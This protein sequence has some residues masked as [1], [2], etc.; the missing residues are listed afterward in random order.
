[1]SSSPAT[2]Y[3]NADSSTPPPSGFFPVVYISG[4]PYQMGYQYGLQAGKYM[5]LS[6][7]AVWGTVLSEYNNNVT[8]VMQELKIYN[9]YVKDNLTAINY[10][11]I[12]QGMAD[13]AQAAGYNVSY[14]DI[15]LINYRVEFEFGLIPGLSDPANSA[16]NQSSACT[17]LAVWGNATSNGELITGSNFDYMPG[18]SGSYQVLVIA[19]PENGN[20]F[21]SIG[22]A[23]TLFTNFGMNNKGVVIESNKA[24]NGRPQDV[25]YGISDFIMDPYALM[26]AS[27]ATEAKNIIVSLPKTNGINRLV[28]D[29]S[30]TAYAIESTASLLGIRTPVNGDYIITTNHFLNT[31]MMPAQVPWNPLAYYPA[32]Y[33]RYITAQKYIMMNYGNITP[34]TVMGIMSSTSYWNGSEWIP[35]SEW[36]GNTINRFAPWGGTLSSKVAI[37][38]QG[39]LYV[40]AGNPGYP[41]WGLLAPGQTG[42][43]VKFVL[44]PSDPTPQT[45]TENLQSEAYGELFQASKALYGIKQSDVPTYAQL[46]QQ[47]ANAESLYWESSHEMSLATLDYAQGNLNSALALYGNASTGFAEVQGIAEY[48]VSVSKNYVSPSSQLSAVNSSLSAAIGSTNSQLGSIS[49]SL[50]SVSNLLSSMSSTLS[51]MSSTVSSIGDSLSSM[52]STLSTVQ[53]EAAQISSI[54]S[55]VLATIVIAIIIL[56]LEILVL[57]RRR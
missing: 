34:Q 5:E 16:N 20:A 40:C 21:V 25:G 55:L 10:S 23:G 43:Y 49:S 19:Y 2:N 57:I 17:N 47:F 41:L 50:S 30:G 18:S 35:N 32:S 27:N 29:T 15:L 22:F 36:T 8:F 44:W 54:N 31:T 38:A 46:S 45:I 12:M 33:Y 14:W 56:V 9:S 6:K 51:T 39:I 1:M 11:A 7:D 28:V 24:P 3:T 26:V 4:T 37:P 48:L 42:Q 13:G 52:S 53:S